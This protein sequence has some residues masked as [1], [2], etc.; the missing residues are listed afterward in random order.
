MINSTGTANGAG[1]EIGNLGGNQSGG[2]PETEATEGIAQ[3][4]EAGDEGAAGE[5][6]NVGPHYTQASGPGTNAPSESLNSI[7]QPSQGG[8]ANAT[9]SSANTAMQVIADTK[10]ANW[11]TGRPNLKSM[12]IRRPIPVVVR[13]NKMILTPTSTNR[14]S[15]D[16]KSQEIS[17][18]QPIHDIT[19]NFTAAVKERIEDWGLAGSGMYWK[20]VLVLNVEPNAQMTAT[21]IVHLLRDSGVEVQLPQTARGSEISPGR[22][23]R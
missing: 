5:K 13:E 7:D 11:A 20:P 15:V 12:A 4:T 9:S 1:P 17:L 6:P 21:R 14:R 18:D 10:G 2:A 23:V 19:E 22:T 8:G 16:S 3:G